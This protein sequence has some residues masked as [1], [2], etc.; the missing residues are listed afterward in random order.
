MATDNGGADKSRN[1]LRGNQVFD[2]LHVLMD[3]QIFSLAYGTV[4]DEVCPM[5]A[6]SL[7]YLTCCFP[8][9]AQR[10]SAWEI[11]AS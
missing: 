6:A 2:S 10:T 4:F 8:V 9:F 11:D 7:Q 3:V 1:F 5:V